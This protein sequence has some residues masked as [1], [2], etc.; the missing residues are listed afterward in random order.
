MARKVLL[1]IGIL[2]TVVGLLLIATDSL[3]LQQPGETDEKQVKQKID[4]KRI[5]REATELGMKFPEDLSKEEIKHQAK[6]VGLKLNSNNITSEKES[7][8]NKPVRIEITSGATAGQ[9][10]QKLYQSKIIKDRQALLELIKKAN[11]E[12]KILAGEYEFDS[13]ISVEKILLNITGNRDQ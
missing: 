2:L 1:G 9:V 3:E 10:V 8:D 6:R 12:N 4:K 11:L 5:I 13:D 7:N